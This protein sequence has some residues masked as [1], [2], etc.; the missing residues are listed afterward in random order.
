VVF[1]GHSQGGHTAL[2]AL[3]QAETYASELTIAGVAL[4]APLWLPQRSWGTILLVPS[5]YP[6]KGD[7][8]TPNAVSVWYHYTHG[9]LLDG[10]GHGGDVFQAS[11]RAAIKQWVDSQ[12]WGGSGWTELAKLGADS[13]E[14]FDQ[15]FIDTI[16]DPASGQ[17]TCADP[18]NPDK[19]L[20]QTWID[21]YQADRPH[22]TGKA[23]SVPIVM[24]YGAKD[25]TIPPERVTCA[26]DRLKKT[27]Q[28]NIKICIEPTAD[29]STIPAL[30]GS[31]TSDWIA[32]LTLGGAATTQAECG[33]D[34]TTLKDS[35]GSQVV[36]NQLP[37]ND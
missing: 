29:H 4:Y 2:S 3:A 32:N 20:C 33:V 6:L 21:R 25:T 5:L 19:A 10:P 24:L 31:F 9:E 37:P 28:A 22:L 18:A 15:H 14:L 26:I 27:D 23:K 12:C 17:S 7:T 8:I 36:C 11:K 13:G 1:T 35:T 34:E 16:A 30:R